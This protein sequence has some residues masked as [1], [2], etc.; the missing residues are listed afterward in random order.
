MRQHFWDS[1]NSNKKKI[2]VQKGMELLDSEKGALLAYI[3]HPDSAALDKL[4]KVTSSRVLSAVDKISGDDSKHQKAKITSQLT[5]DYLR[6]VPSDLALISPDWRSNANSKTSD[7]SPQAK[8]AIRRYQVAPVY[9]YAPLPSCAKK[10]RPEA[11]A[12]SQSELASYCLS[13]IGRAHV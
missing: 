10:E 6:S 11:L 7:Q 13:K 1:P 12:K 4:P 2:A 9:A 5:A 3:H 8:R